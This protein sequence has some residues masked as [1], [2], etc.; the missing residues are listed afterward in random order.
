MQPNVLC[1]DD[2]RDMTDLLRFLLSRAGCEV[3]SAASG[4]A[5]L[6]EVRARAPD[7]VV[8][9]LMLPDLDGFSVCEILRREKAT[10]GIPILMLT[11]WATPDARAHGL[12]LGARDYI[13]KPFRPN[14]LVDRVRE[15]LGA[16]GAAG[17]QLPE[18]VPDEWQPAAPPESAQGIHGSRPDRPGAPLQ[19]ASS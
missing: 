13:T 7:L 4:L 2:E 10:A 3:R 12:N 18:G 9:D 6:A 15:L 19:T 1:V 17:I 8:L 11:A 14:D 5:A 16:K